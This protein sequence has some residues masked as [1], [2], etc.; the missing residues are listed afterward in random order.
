MI[1]KNKFVDKD[2]KGET[3]LADQVLLLDKISNGEIGPDDLGKNQV[4]TLE[5]VSAYE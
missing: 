4:K 3:K 1:G 2:N 5:K